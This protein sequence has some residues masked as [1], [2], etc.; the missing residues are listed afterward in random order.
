[1]GYGFV[2]V[3]TNE[4]F[5]DLYKVGY[6]TGSPFKRAKELSASTSV[7]T[8]FEVVCYAEYADV[9]KHETRVH[10]TVAD[11]RVSARREFFTGPFSRIYEAVMDRD[12]SLARCDHLAPVELWEEEHADH[13]VTGVFQ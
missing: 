6:T 10:D 13:K 9:E 3:M 5:P 4:S 1:M 11:L 2:Y 12:Y 7:P 8:P